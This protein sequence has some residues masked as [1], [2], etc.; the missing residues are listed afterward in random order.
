[1]DV[2]TALIAAEAFEAQASTLPAKPLSKA[3]L[4]T[5]K[6][7]AKMAQKEHESLPETVTAVTP[8]TS[9]TVTKSV[10]DRHE[11]S[12]P[13][14][15]VVN[16]SLPSLRSEESK[17]TPVCP[18]GQTAPEGAER[19]GDDKPKTKRGTRLPKGWTPNDHER[20]LAEKAGLDPQ[21]IDD[22]AVEFGNYWRAKSGAATKLDWTATWHNRVNDLGKRKR[23]RLATRSK[24]SGGGGRRSGGLGEYLAR[25]HGYLED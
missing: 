5:R 18:S 14:V 19:D 9:P 6:Y 4:R 1:M 13:H 21:E 17:N 24:W 3:A 7:R 12:P 16:P 11:T 8:V 25:K 10:T 2:E 15:R 23:E 22:A 20:L